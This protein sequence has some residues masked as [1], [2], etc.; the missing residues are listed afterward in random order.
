MVVWNEIH[1]AG[2]KLIFPLRPSWVPK[3]FFFIYHMTVFR[4]N[5]KFSV[6]LCL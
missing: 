2:E 5:R 4:M 6:G 3:S 1:E